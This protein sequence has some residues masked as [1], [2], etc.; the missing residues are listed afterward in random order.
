MMNLSTLKIPD[1]ERECEEQVALLPRQLI[2]CMSEGEGE[3]GLTLT[4]EHMATLNEYCAQVKAIPLER[5]ALVQWLGYSVHSDVE[6]AVF[7]MHQMFDFMHSHADY[8]SVLQVRC[9]SLPSELRTCA[10]AIDDAGEQALTACERTKALGGRREAW[11]N[12]QF[13]APVVLS[14]EDQAIVDDLAGWLEVVR[15]AANQFHDSVALLREGIEDF[16]DDARFRFRPML[17]RKVEAIRRTQNSPAMLQMRASLAQLDARLRAHDQEYQR[18]LMAVAANRMLSLLYGAT[19]R[20]MR[21]ARDELVETRARLSAELTSR[22]GTEGRLE[23]LATRLEQLITRMQDVTTSASHLQTVWQLIG[24][25][26]ETSIEHLRTME[27]SQ[28]LGI[29]VIHFKNFLAQWAFIEQCA[30]TLEKRLQ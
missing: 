13:E 18:I 5:E 7:L 14:L 29:F 6:L 12:V 4:R 16:R 28:Q 17:G 19:L 24:V 1:T 2:E 26:I 22:G 21:K 10:R 20:K 30:I 23:A 11:Q 3:L 27:N 15:A 25:Y 9:T 8:W